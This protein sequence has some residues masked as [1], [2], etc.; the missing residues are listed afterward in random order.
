MG[1]KE[2]SSHVMQSAEADRSASGVH[3]SHVHRRHTMPAHSPSTLHTEMNDVETGTWQRSDQDIAAES[4][5]T[6]DNDALI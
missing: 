1:F 3:T 6:Y 4:A 5:D 2:R